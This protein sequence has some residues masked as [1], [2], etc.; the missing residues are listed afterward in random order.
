MDG[1]KYCFS[2]CFYLLVVRPLVCATMHAQEGGREE[3][4][5]GGREEGREG[6]RDLSCDVW[7]CR[8]INL[9]L[10][11]VIGDLAAVCC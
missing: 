5:E 10:L 3:G 6:E 11:R 2:N 9:L 8:A 4:R 7:R 1:R